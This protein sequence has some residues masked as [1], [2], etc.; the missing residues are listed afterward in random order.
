M[1]VQSFPLIQ[2]SLV[3]EKKKIFHPEANSFSDQQAFHD[4]QNPGHLYGKEPGFVLCYCQYNLSFS[5][6]LCLDAGVLI[7]IILEEFW[8]RFLSLGLLSPCAEA[9][10]TAS[11]PNSGRGQNSPS[12]KHVARVSPCVWCFRYVAATK[13]ARFQK[14]LPPQYNI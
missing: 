11:A 6:I 9:I 3:K 1:G 5:S 12:L 10:K 2:W 13:A 8:R 7:C 4:H 14:Y